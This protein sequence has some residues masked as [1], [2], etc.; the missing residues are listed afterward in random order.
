MRQNIPGAVS[1][2]IVSEFQAVPAR[3]LLRLADSACA[4]RVYR[5][6]RQSMPKPNFWLVVTENPYTFEP[7]DFDRRISTSVIR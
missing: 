1:S 7:L 2:L 5:S 4:F 6:V 3:Y